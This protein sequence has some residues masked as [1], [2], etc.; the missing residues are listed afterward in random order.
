V[1]LPDEV[2]LVTD[3]RYGDQA[4]RQLA[5]ANAPTPGDRCVVDDRLQV[6]IRGGG[7]RGRLGFASTY[8][9]SAVRAVR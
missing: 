7:G 2:V 6:L 5:A 3:G 4:E 1:L 9:A 8:S